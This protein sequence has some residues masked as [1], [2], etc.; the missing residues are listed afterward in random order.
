MTR[1]G[2][3]RVRWPWPPPGR[4][5]FLEAEPRLAA[6]FDVVKAATSAGGCVPWAAVTILVD[7][8][9]GPD[10]SVAVVTQVPAHVETAARGL[11]GLDL[12]NAVLA[13]LMSWDARADFAPREPMKP[14]FAE[15]R[16]PGVAQTKTVRAQWVGE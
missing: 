10:R 9:V 14:T 4:H 8:L 7:S 12:R 6:L 16:S 11:R 15:Q 1:A 5:A 3:V 2:D 13:E